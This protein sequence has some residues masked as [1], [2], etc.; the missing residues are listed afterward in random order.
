MDKIRNVTNSINIFNDKVKRRLA[1]INNTI[2]NVM[3]DI[4][5]PYYSVVDVYNT[6]KDCTMAPADAA[7]RMIQTVS[8]LRKSVELTLNDITSLPEQWVEKIGSVEKSLESEIRAYKSYFEDNIQELENSVNK[9]YAETVSGANPEIVI[10]S[11]LPGVKGEEI[12]AVQD[13]QGGTVETIVA[14]GYMRH[15]ATSETT[16]EKMAEIYLG[17][18]DKA[19]ML[20]IING[21]S[22]DD[23]INPGDQLKIP[24]LSENSLNSLNQI[25]GSA[26]NRDALGIDIALE[27]G[28]LQVGPNGDFMQQVDYE[29]MNQAISMRLSE[30]IG[31]R[32]RLNTYGIRN[33]GGMP[34][35]VATAYIA[36]S[37][38]DTVMQDPRVARVDNLIFRGIGD[39]LFVS[40]DF[41]TYDGVLRKYKGSL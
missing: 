38:K 6:F 17:D 21:V 35:S 12:A 24:I 1:L 20:A 16:L 34:D 30:S 31:R 41:Y 23:E 7:L 25:F 36:T 11:K 13:G 39:A 22:G 28:I 32:I 19:Q 5:G 2:D 18:P 15:I 26:N 14:Y 37:I 40:F 4:V 3:R 33:V 10:T 27:N 29:N 9:K 8:D